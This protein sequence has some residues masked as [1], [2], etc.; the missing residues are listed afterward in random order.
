MKGPVK[1]FLVKQLI[2]DTF[3]VEGNGIIEERL[4]LK[5]PYIL[6]A[7]EGTNKEFCK[8]LRE[9]FFNLITSSDKNIKTLLPQDTRMAHIKTNVSR[10]T[11]ISCV[12]I[13]KE[14]LHYEATDTRAGANE[15]EIDWDL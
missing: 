6:K 11:T 9:L 4:R 8:G 7:K 3:D 1:K 13:F 10:K 2:I 5:T 14:N 15:D 12:I